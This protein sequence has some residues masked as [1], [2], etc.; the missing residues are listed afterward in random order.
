MRSVAVMLGHSS[1]NSVPV[2][3]ISMGAL[4]LSFLAV[5]TGHSSVP[6]GSP[7]VVVSVSCCECYCYD[8]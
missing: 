4:V 7:A 6:S 2:V 1:G 8:A 5:D 3:H